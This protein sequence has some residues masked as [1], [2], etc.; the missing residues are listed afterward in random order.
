VSV[1]KIDIKKRSTLQEDIRPA[2]FFREAF[3]TFQYA[4]KAAGG[5]I[6]RYY[7]IGGH[8]IRLC[9][10]GPSL[11]PFITPA[12]EHLAAKL[13][14]TP[15]LTVCL[16]DSVSTGINMPP[17]PWTADDYLARGEVCGYNNDR[18]KTAFHLGSCVLS[19]L[20]AGQ[21]L[22]IYWI[23][24]ARQIPFYESGSPLRTIMHWFMDNHKLQFVHAASVGTPDGGVLLAGKG[25]SGK[26]TTAL[27]CISYG[28]LYAGDDHVLL[29]MDP[30]PFAYSL[31]NTAK[32]DASCISKFPNLLP[33]VKNPDRLDTEKALIFLYEHYPD[34]IVN[35][36]SLKAIL[37]PSITGYVET[38]LRKVSPAASLA[39]LAPSTIFSLPGAG[40]DDF[41]FLA[42]FVKQLPSYVLELGT[43]LDRVPDVILDLLF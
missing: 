9:F 24:D 10:A 20:D 14:P 34:R 15:S 42:Q 6:D 11:I 32:L 25:G 28:L 5:H 40:Q 39:A 18:Y 19:M 12:M 22:A 3:Q 7:I 30:V 17:S 23:R 41:K 21:N 4:G 38:R 8:V 33:A 36:F 27:A 26:S 2:T 37:L 35:G 31:Y 29:T 1:G 43:D 16:W 13:C